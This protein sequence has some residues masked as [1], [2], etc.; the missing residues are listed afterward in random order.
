VKSFFAYLGVA[1]ALVSIICFLCQFVYDGDN[2]YHLGHAM[3]YA[4]KGPFYRSFPWPA[5]SVI[6]QHN[7]D[8][9]WGFHLLLS[10]LAILKDKVLIL[11]VAPGVLMVLNL[12]ISR[13]AVIRLGMNQWYG[14]ALLPASLG[15]ISRMDT[16]RPQ[17]LSA[18]LLVL[19]FA[20]IVS[21]APWLAI[22]TSA[23]IGFL[24]PTLSYLI[25][26]VG[27]CTFIQRGISKKGWNCW[28]ELSCLVVALTVSCIRPGMLD[29]LQLI[30]IQLFDLMVVRR[31]GEIKNFG[32]ELDRVNL[33]YFNR[34]YLGPVIAV[35]VGALCLLRFRDKE[36]KAW[37]VWGALGIVALSFAISV[38]LTRR[39][40]DQFAPFAI[41]AALCLFHQCKGLSKFTAV[42]FTLYG[43]TIT[44]LFLHSNLTRKAKFNAT[45]YRRG[46]EWLAAHSEPGEI[47]GHGVWSDFGPLFYWNSHNRYLG[48]MDPI[49]QYRYNPETYWLMTVN[50]AARDLGKT[51]KFNPAIVGDKEEDISTAWPRDLK[52]KWLFCASDWNIELQDEL[53]KDKHTRIAYK[54]SSVVIFEF[55]PSNPIGGSGTVS[56][57]Q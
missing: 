13:L 42:A 55:L 39:G 32:V 57:G 23:L 22:L 1:A 50:C 8:L 7:S 24:H 30:K 31:A 35:A 44:S 25:V 15:F 12:L 16:V 56:S 26:M 19:L 37:A 36:K 48:G 28:L 53:K 17:A 54:D 27:V 4:E 43:I 29:G 6:S 34:A 52:T 38:F 3:L 21:E 46:A 14:F 47:V 45:D 41:L 10:P 33:G 49:F 18:A 5:Y 11:A 2:F 51:S 9:W 20:A 40:A